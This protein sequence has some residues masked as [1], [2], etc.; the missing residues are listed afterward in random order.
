MG[1]GRLPPWL[2][3]PFYGNLINLSK[4][5]VS[6]TNFSTKFSTK[7]VCLQ[8]WHNICRW[9]GIKSLFNGFKKTWQIQFWIYS[10]WCNNHHK[11]FFKNNF[12]THKALTTLFRHGF[13]GFGAIGGEG[14][15]SGLTSRNWQM[16][17]LK[18]GIKTN[19]NTSSIAQP[20]FAD[21]T[22]FPPKTTDFPIYAFLNPREK[23]NYRFCS[24]FYVFYIN[25]SKLYN[26]HRSYFRKSLF[27]AIVISSLVGFKSRSITWH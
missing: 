9:R 23:N 26:T 22:I 11:I 3:R 2:W 1:S 24:S 27:C 13:F 18:I 21:V 8:I 20:Y 5:H 15:L 17:K 6:L 10:V 14:G 25:I 4:N 12:S 7:F 19:D 16:L